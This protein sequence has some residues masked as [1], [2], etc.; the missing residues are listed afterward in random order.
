MAKKPEAAGVEETPPDY[1]PTAREVEAFKAFQ[2]S[3]LKRSPAPRLKIEKAAGNTSLL[4]TDHPDNALA[5]VLIME[6]IGTADYEFYDVFLSQ[7]SNAG[8]Q[9]KEPDPRGINFMLSV[10]KGIGPRDQLEAMLAAQMAAVHMASMTFA[11][12]LAHVDMHPRAIRSVAYI[13][14]DRS[15]AD[16]AA[17]QN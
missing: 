5:H 14:D 6:A 8:T 11:R 9:G 2:A 3:N 7:L 1:V 10:V 15:I 4:G 12:R 13:H 16:E 17:C